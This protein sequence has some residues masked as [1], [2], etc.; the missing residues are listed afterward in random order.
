[1]TLI[2]KLAF[3]ILL[4]AIL[5]VQATWIFVDARR[6]GESYYWLWGLFGLLNVPSSLIVYLLVMKYHKRR[7]PACGREVQKGQPVCPGCGSVVAGTCPQCHD[8]TRM[9]WNYCPN[10]ACKLK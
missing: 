5:L 6:R 9:E 7:C 10:C 4:P 1:M 3:F 2:T 8:A